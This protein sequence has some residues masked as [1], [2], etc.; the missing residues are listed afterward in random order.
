MFT[1]FRR[2]AVAVALAATAFTVPMFAQAAPA[3][4]HPGLAAPVSVVAPDGAL[5][6]VDT[7]GNRVM[8]FAP[9]HLTSTDRPFD[10]PTAVRIDSEGRVVVE[11]AAGSHTLDRWVAPVVA[12]T[13]AAAAPVAPAPSPAASPEQPNRVMKNCIGFIVVC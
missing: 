10:R 9:G 12:Q 3:H 8:K 7:H 4:A 13:P 5:Y 11:D 1:R 6:V 2:T